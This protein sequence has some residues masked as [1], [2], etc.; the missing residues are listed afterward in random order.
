MSTEW[1]MGDRL[2]HAGRPEWGIGE[3]RAAEA[4]TQNG[5]RC[6]RLTIRF[7]RAGV[8]TL[9]TAFADLRPASSMPLLIEQPKPDTSANGS[10]R[11]PATSN[12]ISARTPSAGSESGGGGGWLREAEQ[13]SITDQMTRLPE[14]ATDPFR[15]RKARFET[16]LGLYRFT[17][18]GASLLDWASIQSGMKDP[19]S[20]FSRHELERLFDRFRVNLDGH[21]KK[22]G[23][24]LKK[25]DPSGMAAAIAA[26]P[27]AAKQ[28]VKRLDIGR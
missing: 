4:Q 3:V 15:T 12:G 28:A 7:E 25:E 13:G 17:P 26:A 8:K 11:S 24:E 23:I 27:P 16:S 10:H 2:M 18:T 21:I 6:Q 9:S 19:L 22:L 20:R 14:Q 5:V 1:K